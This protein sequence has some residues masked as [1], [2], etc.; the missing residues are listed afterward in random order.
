[1]KRRIALLACL[2]LATACGAPQ[3]G[4]PTPTDEDLT[5][6][7][8]TSA[9]GPV[10]PLPLVLEP[11]P[12]R[13]GSQIQ[14]SGRGF[15]AGETVNIT[16]TKGAEGP[17][18]FSLGQAEASPQGTLDALV[19]LL[20]DEL[21]SGSHLLDAVGTSSGRHS[22]GTLW[23]QAREPWIV[24]DSYTLQAN[25]DV[26]LVDGGFEPLDTVEATLEPHGEHAPDVP[27][28]SLARQTT[29]QAGNAQYAKFKLAWTTRAGTYSLVLRSVAG[30]QEL[31]REVTVEGLKP[32]AELSP[33]SG[34]AGVPVHLNVRGFAPGERV[35]VGLGSAS[36]EVMTVFADLDGNLWG[37]GPV[38]IP[39]T[40]LVGRL[41]IVLTGEGSAAV[42]KPEFTIQEPKPWL[43]LTLWWG[44][45]GVPVGFGGG[46][47]IGGEHITF[48]A[49]SA[50]APV[51]AE[52]DADDYGW[53]HISNTAR[54]PM[55]ADGPVTFVAFGET[56]HATASAVFSVS[57]PFDLKPHPTVGPR[58][59]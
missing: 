29:D 33:W 25:V 49:G 7:A 3:S 41:P 4:E 21:E 2:W 42:V 28:V 35:H 59:R 20:P 6:V 9:R 5:P 27:P 17:Q 40:A 24:L 8:V 48:H 23:I 39:Q 43:E 47:W 38:R 16:V 10:G 18:A 26:N 55:D 22:T 54:V 31:R 44:A 56:S 37:A 51:L 15:N 1:M 19:L 12:T 53:L 58:R 45:P 13:Q 14:I 30:G 36:N 34:P 57:F 11:I 32:D 52:G 50:L 46:G